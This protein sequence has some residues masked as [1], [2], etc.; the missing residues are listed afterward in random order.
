M[1]SDAIDSD[2]DVGPPGKRGI[3][4]ADNATVFNMDHPRDTIYSKNNINKDKK[5]FSTNQENNEH[6]SILMNNIEGKDFS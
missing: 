4:I 3:S 6:I 1:Y 2:E 5:V